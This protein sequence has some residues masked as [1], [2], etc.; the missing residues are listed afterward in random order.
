MREISRAVATSRSPS[1]PGR[2]KEM[3]PCAATAR[4]LWELQAKAKAES[5]S[6]KMKPPWAMPWPLTMFGWTVIASIASPGLIS[7]DLH[8]EAL[9]GVVF[10]PHRL[11]AGAREIVGRKRGLDVHRGVSALR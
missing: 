2:M 5:A 4:S 6:V 1:L 10:L 9:A 8:A 7:Q 3:L 11:G